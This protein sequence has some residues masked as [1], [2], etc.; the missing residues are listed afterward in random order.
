MRVTPRGARWATCL[1]LTWAVG[2]AMFNHGGWGTYVQIVVCSISGGYLLAI[3]DRLHG[4][5]PR[6]PGSFDPGA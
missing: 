6:G 1:T 2:W 5:P 3:Y 4:G